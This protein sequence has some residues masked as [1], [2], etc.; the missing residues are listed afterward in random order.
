M[1][2]HITIELSPE[3]CQSALDALKTYKEQI[4]PKLE[5]ICRRL[6]EIGVEAARASITGEYGNN[7]VTV[8]S[9]VKIRN[10]YKIVMSGADVYFVEFGTGDQVDAH[11]DTSVPV[12]WGSW[13][14]EHE[15]KLWRTGFWWY[16]KE[17]LTGT[18]AQ[19]PMYNAEKAMRANA[20]RIAQEVMAK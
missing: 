4:K 9:P 16:N 2:K 7:D 8:E 3:S 20:R 15:Q 12:A 17:K 1:K 5:E 14:A 18:P 19:M 6:A 13:S 10:G 11:Y